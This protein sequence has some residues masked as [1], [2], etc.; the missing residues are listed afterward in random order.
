MQAP[1]PPKEKSQMLK[2]VADAAKAYVPQFKLVKTVSELMAACREVLL[3]VRA[4]WPRVIL[5]ES[6]QQ[7]SLE[8]VVRR[9]NQGYTQ[10]PQQS[11]SEP[12]FFKRHQGDNMDL[13]DTIRYTIVQSG[14]APVND[15][16]KHKLEERTD[17]DL[18]AI[19]QY[20]VDDFSSYQGFL[21]RKR[22]LHG[23]RLDTESAERR[24]CLTQPFDSRKPAAQFLNLRWV[25]G[26]ELCRSQASSGRSPRSLR[27]L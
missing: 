12:E 10:I 18:I 4:R 17:P 23:T 8:E 14:L 26:S 5:T 16:L 24:A 25:S 20:G 13:D 9:F 21:G 19:G 7:A 2:E 15:S 6:F 1:L 22:S 27:L 11:Y 3:K